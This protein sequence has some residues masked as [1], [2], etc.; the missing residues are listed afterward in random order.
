M[1]GESNSALNP[2]QFSEATAVIESRALTNRLSRICEVTCWEYAE[3]WL[4]NPSPASNIVLELSPARAFKST[5]S[6]DQARS[7]QQFRL[8]STAFILAAGEGLPGRVWMS[9][10]YEWI[11]DTSAQS[12]TYFLRNQIARAFGVRTS[13]GLPITHEQQLQAVLAVFQSKACPE[14]PGLIVQTQAIAQELGP[15]VHTLMHQRLTTS[16]EESPPASAEF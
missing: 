13:L 10:R 6:T 2:V 1:I 4:P 9:Q 3:L 16:M 11:V 5:L 12:E 7:W 15:V 14:D 8:C